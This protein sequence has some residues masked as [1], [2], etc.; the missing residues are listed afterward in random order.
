MDK[1]EVTEPN[2][3]NLMVPDITGQDLILPKR[4]EVQSLVPKM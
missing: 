3:S 2:R 4:S 1:L